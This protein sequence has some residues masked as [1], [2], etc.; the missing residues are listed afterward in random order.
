MVVLLEDS[1]GVT[2]SNATL[3]RINGLVTGTATV[4]VNVTSSGDGHF[5]VQFSLEIAGEYQVSP[6]CDGV[7]MI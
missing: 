7:W 2:V 1:R 5:L 6:M 4:P 3:A